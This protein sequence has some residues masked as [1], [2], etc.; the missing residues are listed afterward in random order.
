MIANLATQFIALLRCHAIAGRALA[1]TTFRLPD[2]FGRRR[3][4]QVAALFTTAAKTP[5]AGRHGLRK[6]G[7]RR[8]QQQDSD[9]EVH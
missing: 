4:S 8:D 7:A 6:R 1:G 5:A 2:R 3:T 9:D